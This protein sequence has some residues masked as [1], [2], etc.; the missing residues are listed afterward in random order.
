MYIQ[1]VFSESFLI[2]FRNISPHKG[3]EGDWTAY[4]ETACPP[5]TFISGVA[6]KSDTKGK[7]E[8]FKDNRGAT[9]LKAIC[10]DRSELLSTAAL[11]GKHK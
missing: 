6:L 3:I 1:I 5:K 8:A 4:E 11:R 9:D 10:T 7:L 2:F